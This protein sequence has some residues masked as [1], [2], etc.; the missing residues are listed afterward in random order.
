MPGNLMVNLKG[1]RQAKEVARKELVAKRIKAVFEDFA[2]GKGDYY[3]RDFAKA[4]K[5]YLKDPE[6]RGVTGRHVDLFHN[7]SYE[8][9]ELLGHVTQEDLDQNFEAVEGLKTNLKKRGYELKAVT[10][11]SFGTLT[12]D[13]EP[14]DT[15]EN[16]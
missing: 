7:P 14:I 4:Y 3:L 6:Q 2:I 5:E 10:P 1:S 13:I 15:P 8:R 12:I 11:F 16:S 9:H